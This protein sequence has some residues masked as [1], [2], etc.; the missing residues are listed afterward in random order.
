MSNTRSVRTREETPPRPAPNLSDVIAI[1]SPPNKNF[2]PLRDTLAGGRIGRMKPR[3][4]LLCL[5]CLIVCLMAGSGQ[6]PKPSINIGGHVLTLGMPES[7]VL[8]QLGTDLIL[9]KFL[10]GENL[11]RLH[12]RQSPPGLSKGK[13]NRDSL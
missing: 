8:E 3:N 10:A 13:L 9:R 11:N 12:T 4:A 5:F 7:T 6:P 2:L 1:V